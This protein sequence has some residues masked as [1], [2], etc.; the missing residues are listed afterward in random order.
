MGTSILKKDETRRFHGFS[1]D[2][3]PNVIMP[4]MNKSTGPVTPSFA[5]PPPPLPLPK[6]LQ[7]PLPCHQPD[8]LMK[9][10]NS[11]TLTNSL[12]I[13]VASHV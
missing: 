10:E 6:P 1:M 8:P 9:N 7:I 3:S 11:A 4:S 12:S 13:P 5:S 2:F